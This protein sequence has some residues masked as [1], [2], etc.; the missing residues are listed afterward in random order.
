MRTVMQV[1][2]INPLQCK[3]I[4]GKSLR[5]LGGGCKPEKD[6]KKQRCLPLYLRSNWSNK[7]MLK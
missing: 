2:P 5:A 3:A 6:E 4:L 7:G 1:L